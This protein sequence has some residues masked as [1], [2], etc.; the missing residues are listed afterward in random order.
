MV[1]A[2]SAIYIKNSISHHPLVLYSKTH[3]QAST[4]IINLDNNVPTAISFIYC[5]DPKITYDEF[6][7]FSLGD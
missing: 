1:H 7:N 6:Q 3:L 5:P 4:I 2:S